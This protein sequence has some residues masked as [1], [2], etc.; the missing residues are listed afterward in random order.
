MSATN[1]K[2]KLVGSKPSPASHST[3]EERLL[4]EVHFP[5]PLAERMQEIFGLNPAPETLEDFVS[6]WLKR[7][8]STRLEDLVLPEA[9]R[10]QVMVEGR[11]RYVWCA[12]D[13]MILA[14]LEDEVLALVTSDPHTTQTIELTL[15][16]SGIRADETAS[17]NLVLAFGFSRDVSSE[18]KRSCCPNLNLFQSPETYHAWCDSQPDAMT[19]HLSL[20]QAWCLAVEWASAIRLATSSN[21]ALPR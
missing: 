10:H 6:Q 14:V 5:R 1:D 7:S 16:P 2:A 8:C 15:S 3:R 19:V 21:D 20:R 13:A 12:L 11:A 18:L 4:R 9:T 17:Q